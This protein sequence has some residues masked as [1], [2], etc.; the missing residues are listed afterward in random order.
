MLLLMML[1][2]CVYVLL[3]FVIMFLFIGVSGVIVV[4]L[5]KNVMGMLVVIL[6]VYGLMVCML[7]VDGVV[8]FV[9]MFFEFLMNLMRIVYFELVFGLMRCCYE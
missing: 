7:S 6:S 1:F 9:M 4:S 2:G 5:G 8:L 3:N